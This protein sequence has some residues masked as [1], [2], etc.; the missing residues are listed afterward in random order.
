MA[1]FLVFVFFCFIESQVMHFL[2]QQVD[3]SCLK[4]LPS[5]IPE[6]LYATECKFDLTP[7]P[8]FFFKIESGRVIKS[9]TVG[10][11]QFELELSSDPRLTSIQ[12]FESPVLSAVLRNGAKMAHLDPSQ[13]YCAIGEL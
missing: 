9:R 5:F 6:S 8:F 2:F 12:L 13:K 1:F 11:G 10:L 4:K 3:N 7:K